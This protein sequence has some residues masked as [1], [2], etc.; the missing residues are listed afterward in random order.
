MGPNGMP[1]SN[2]NSERI[3]VGDRV[4]LVKRG[5]KG[6]WQ[7]E[8]YFQGHRR[9]STKTR[10]LKTARQIALVLEGQLIQGTFDISAPSVEITR[11]TITS[12][13]EQFKE[14]QETKG[15]R[16]STIERYSS[17]FE[18][19]CAFAAKAKVTRVDQVTVPLID[20]YRAMRNSEISRHTLWQD[21]RLLRDFF[22]WCYARGYIATNLLANEKYQLP[23]TKKKP[24]VLT[25]EQVNL[26]LREATP[27]RRTY[28]SLLAFTGMR[29][30]E[31]RN[32]LVEDVDLDHG[33]IYIVSRPGCETKTGQ[34]WKAPVHPRLRKVLQKYKPNKSGWYFTAMA[35]RKYPKGDHHIDPDDLNDDFKATLRRV[36]IPDGKKKGGFTLHSLRHF[37]KSHAIAQGVPREYVD[38]WQGHSPG[39]KTA[40]DVYVHIQDEESQRWIQKID[41][42]ESDEITSQISD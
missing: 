17:I 6:I 39:R 40:S 32:L 13:I 24:S 5:K 11:I 3:L 4:T 14:Y 21:S 42:S 37:F 25:L 1:P 28:F 23:S 35:S 19:F 12:A 26:I 2:S 7:M 8:F 10:N 41:F 18:R 29:S 34:D 9:R 30:G 27:T 33:W 36:D 38:D 31:L 16:K 15:N 22:G 20:R